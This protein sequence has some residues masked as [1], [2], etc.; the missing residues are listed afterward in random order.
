MGKCPSGQR[1]RAVNPSATPSEVQILPGPRC[2]VVETPEPEVRGS[3]HVQVAGT[4][5][6]LSARSVVEDDL[7][8]RDI[9]PAAELTADLALDSHLGE[10]V[11]GV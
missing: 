11:L 7:H 6:R 10:S 4:A 2:D 5:R 9:L 3:L 1:E 8:D